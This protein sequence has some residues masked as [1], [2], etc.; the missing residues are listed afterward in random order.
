MTETKQQEEEGA[1]AATCW[2]L[3]LGSAQSRPDRIEPSG[4][5]SDGINANKTRVKPSEHIIVIALMDNSPPRRPR[6]RLERNDVTPLPLRCGGGNKHENQLR[7]P[8]SLY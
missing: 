2:A 3:P 8:L 1:R 5:K 4:I 7:L 6:R